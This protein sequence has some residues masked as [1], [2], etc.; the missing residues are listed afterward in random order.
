MHSLAQA[1]HWL[2]EGS[3]WHGTEGIPARTFEHVQISVTSGAQHAN[4]NRCIA[5]TAV[6]NGGD[7]FELDGISTWTFIGTDSEN[8]GGYNFNFPGTMPTTEISVLGG[9]FEGAAL[10]DFNFGGINVSKNSFIGMNVG[11]Q[12]RFAGSPYTGFGNLWWPGNSPSQLALLNGSMLD[13][14][15]GEASGTTFPSL[16]IRDTENPWAVTDIFRISRTGTGQGNIALATDNYPLRIGGTLTVTKNEVIGGNLTVKGVI[17][18][19]ADHFKIDHP[20]DPAHK[21]LSHSVID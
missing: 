17:N 20:L 4:S 18:K 1:L 12:A 11:S 10:A 3:H 21:F 7:G 16:W 2:V 8:N 9:D 5:C 6:G 19:G 14:P 13:L 15:I